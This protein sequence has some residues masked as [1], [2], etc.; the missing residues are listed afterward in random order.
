MPPSTVF[1]TMLFD[2]DQTLIEHRSN[3]AELLH[4][5]F[6]AFE[7][8]LPDVDSAV[9][10]QTLRQKANDMWT[11]MFDGVLAGDVARPYTFRNTLRALNA[12][13]ALAEDMLEVF[14]QTMLRSTRLMDGAADV[15]DALNAAG[16]KTAVVT[17]GFTEMQMRKAQHHGLDR[18]TR[19]VLASESA[20]FHKP[21]PRIFELALARLESQAP[22]A[23]F[24]GDNIRADIR[25]ARNAGLSAGL[26]DP[27]GAEQ[28]KLDGAPQ[29]HRPTHV[30]T[31]LRDIL[32]LL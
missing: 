20:G 11:M 7:D 19:F 22:G 2:M 12:D 21:D 24:V 17:N 8:K 29:E 9:F 6:T 31:H 26:L 27:T 28:K 1:D 23:L 16:I 25:G 15:L 18:L 14:E 3:G 30:F 4:E 13:V 5:V 32:D 10:A